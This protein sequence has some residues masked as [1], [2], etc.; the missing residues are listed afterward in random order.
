MRVGALVG[1]DVGADD[2]SFRQISERV[3]PEVS[4]METAALV[5]E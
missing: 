5:V 2:R 3:N 4:P 1:P